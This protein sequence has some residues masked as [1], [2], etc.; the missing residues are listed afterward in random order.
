MAP[1]HT[2]RPMYD[3]WE[4]SWHQFETL[5]PASSWPWKCCPRATPPEPMSR[6]ASSPR[7]L[8]LTGLSPAITSIAVGIVGGGRIASM[9]ASAARLTDRWRLL[10]ALSSDPEHAKD[11][12]TLYYLPEERAYT[13]YQ[14]RQRQSRRIRKGGCGDD[15][16]A[17]SCAF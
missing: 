15:H 3:A 11:R 4:L 17:Q 7:P 13:S 1:G 9:Q 12:A 14:A 6:H 8:I 10:R 5:T 16:N 2:H